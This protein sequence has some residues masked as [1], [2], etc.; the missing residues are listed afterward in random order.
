MFKMP[1]MIY[2]HVY[3]K[4]TATYQPHSSHLPSTYPAFLLIISRLRSV[5][6]RYQPF[7]SDPNY[8][9]AV[10]VSCHSLYFKPHFTLSRCLQAALFGSRPGGN[11]SLRLPLFLSVSPPS[12][13]GGNSSPGLP[14][15]QSV[16]TGLHCC[17]VSWG[18]SLLEQGAPTSQPE[19]RAATALLRS[20]GAALIKWRKKE[21]KKEK[22]EREWKK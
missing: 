15:E 17:A 8:P 14:W 4:K 9:I 22:N 20:T 1:N 10:G 7:S 3:K 11:Q 19:S 6:T 18:S 2:T 13:G 12:S 21:R 16:E 5:P